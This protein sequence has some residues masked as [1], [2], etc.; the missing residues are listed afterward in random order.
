MKFESS[1]GLCLKQNERNLEL[2][3]SKMELMGCV[4]D[5]RGE[6][7]ASEDSQLK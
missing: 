2:R 4:T 5:K 3:S 6:A 7:R 1:N